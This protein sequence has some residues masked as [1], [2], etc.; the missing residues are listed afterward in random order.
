MRAE[1]SIQV[2]NFAEN[3]A[4]W[5]PTLDVV[6]M[7]DEVG[8]DRVVVSDHILYG[9]NLEAYAD[10]SIGGSKGGKQPTSPDG[11]WLEPLTLLSV[12]AG[13]TTRVRLGTAILLA[14]L[15]PAAV[16]AKQLAT[17]DVLSGGRVDLGIGVGWQR[18]EYE[19]CGLDFAQ[20]GALLDQCVEI[21][22]R[23]WTEQTVSLDAGGIRFDRIHSMP[24]PVQPGGVPVWVSGRATKR[25][26]T[27]VARFGAGWI[28]WGDDIADPVPGIQ[29]MREACAAVGRDPAGL[30]V[31]GMLPVVRR[32]G[33]ADVPATVARVP[34]LLDIGVTDFRL[35]SRW[36][37]DPAAER[38]FLEAIVPAFRTAAGR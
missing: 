1:L 3:P 9:E 37:A 24:K 4:S 30:Q 7:A 16:L 10:P 6:R 5:Q 36:A 32:D 26:A 18:E 15:R 22:Q 8:V 2:A 28:P 27:R 19:A 34:S 14:A 25:T 31:Q 12:C 21:C 13:I 35:A 38:A 11:H 17:L 23:L 29:L 20:R 33:V